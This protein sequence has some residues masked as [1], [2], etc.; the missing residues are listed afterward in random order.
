M[1]QI[2]SLS[3]TGKNHNLKGWLK[4][5]EGGRTNK[6]RKKILCKHGSNRMDREETASEELKIFKP[7]ISAP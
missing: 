6:L 4:N 1:S 5:P 2:Q 7:N 3:P